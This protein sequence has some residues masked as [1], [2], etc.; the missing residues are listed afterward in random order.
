MSEQLSRFDPWINE[1]GPSAF[2]LKE[3]LQPAAGPG[4]VI[5]PPTFASEGY[6]IDGEG[7]NS[8]C[9]I[10]SVGSQANRLEPVFKLAA[11]RGLVPQI[12]IKVQERV[13][14]LLI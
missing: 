5:F 4:E 2:I 13:V 14:N 3:F 6:V 1:G 10:D 9:L 11:Y 12:E 8:V 7:E